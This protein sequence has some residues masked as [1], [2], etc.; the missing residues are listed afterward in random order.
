MIPLLILSIEN[1]DDR[2]FMENLFITYERLMYSEILKIVKDH[3][4]TDDILQSVIERLIDKIAL[5]QTLPESKLINYIISSVRNTAFNHLRTKKRHPEESYDAMI[6]IRSIEPDIDERIIT[7][8]RIA[9]AKSAWE[10]LDNRSA[11]ILEMKYILEKANEEIAAEL[12]IE[13]DSVRMYISRARK[14]FKDKMKDA[15][16]E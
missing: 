8:E 11:R 14:A 9:N 3:W 2:D 1:S 16:T 7:R 12:G 5:L 4:A 15:E 10:S 13:K 6:Y